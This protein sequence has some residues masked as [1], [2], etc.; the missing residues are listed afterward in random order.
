[1]DQ[2]DWCSKEFQAV[3]LTAFYLFTGGPHWINKW[4]LPSNQDEALNMLFNASSGGWNRTF[5]EQTCNT[6]YGNVSVVVPAWCCWYGISC[7]LSSAPCPPQVPAF[8]QSVSGICGN[9]S[10]G[11]VTRIGLA[12]NNVRHFRGSLVDAHSIYLNMA[13]SI[14]HS[15]QESLMVN[16]T[17]TPDTKSL[18][19]KY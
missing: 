5:M 17:L 9:C 10:V 15:C 7:C 12:Y 14:A 19:L 11:L 13:Y 16:W 1:M 6:M 8:D 2:V 4:P 18:S 3:G